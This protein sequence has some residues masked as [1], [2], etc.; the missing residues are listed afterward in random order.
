MATGIRKKIEDHLLDI[1]LTTEPGGTNAERYKK[2]FAGMDDKA[3]DRYMQDIRDKK[4]RLD[5]VIPNF[6]VNVKMRDIYAAA[7]KIGLKIGERI[8]FWD[9]SSQRYYLTPKEYMVLLLPIRR[10]K[11]YLKDKMSVPDSDTKT[12]LLSGQVVK[13]DKGASLSFVEAQILIS[14]G[15]D[16]SISELMSVRGGNSHAYA[17]F[18][19]AISETG[20]VRL[21]DIETRSTVRSAVVASVYFRG[22]HLW[23]NLVEGM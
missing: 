11:Q 20:T 5:F 13:P 3:F 22:M 9:E 16:K 4:V 12:D 1:I 15:L 21:S 6:K 19:G 8:Q 2:M 23:N 18:K 14:K 17:A 10:V 7:D